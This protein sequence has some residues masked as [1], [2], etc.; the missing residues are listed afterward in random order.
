M[1]SLRRIGR[2]FSAALVLVASF[3]VAGSAQAQSTITGRVTDASGNGVPGANVVVPALGLGV[4]ANTRVDG[5]YTIT[6]PS[7]TVGRE[8]IVTARRIGFAPVSRN[9]T[10]TAGSQTQNFQLS[11]DATKIED[12]VVT[13]VAE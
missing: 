6:L 9:V 5:T 7:S 13:G 10:I 2:A 12:V 8:V 4:G 3:T 1:I 11:Q